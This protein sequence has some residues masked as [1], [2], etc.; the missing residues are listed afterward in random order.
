MLTTRFIGYGLFCMISA[1]EELLQAARSFEAIR[2]DSAGA[3]RRLSEQL[4]VSAQRKLE[5]LGVTAAQIDELKR[6]GVVA[7]HLV[8]HTPLDGTIVRKWAMEGKY[9]KTGDPLYQIADLTKVWLLLDIYEAD[10]HWIAPFQEVSVTAQSSP[11][12]TFRGE[13][14][15]VDP[16]VD[17]ATRTIKVRVNVDNPDRRLKPEMYVTALIDVA[18][19]AG[20]HAATPAARG[21]FACPM[22]TWETA[23]AFTICPICEMDMVATESLPGHKSP[24]AHVAVS[25]VP[26]EAVMR[27][28]QRSLVFIETDVGVYRGVEVKIGPVAQDESGRRF[29]P[30]LEGLD[31]GQKVVT[32]GNF[33]IDSQMQLAGKPSLFN[34]RGLA[35]GAAHDHSAHTDEAPTGERN[36]ADD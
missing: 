10:L 12:D 13:I 3:S 35:P 4:V 8:I 14:A 24:R 30:I 17:S 6:T 19:G 29:Y 16:V 21:A 18:V 5:L 15:F 26:A 25:S 9:V 32:R 27:T 20:G 36:E 31:E 11:G 1:Q 23:D 7:S 2:G 22:H 34:A 28:G 33:V